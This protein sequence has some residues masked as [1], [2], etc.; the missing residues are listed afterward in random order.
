MPFANAFVENQRLYV[1]F[2]SIN[3]TIPVH[4]IKE[5]LEHFW[6]DKRIKEVHLTLKH[7]RYSGI[8]ETFI[9]RK[10]ISTGNDFQLIEKKDG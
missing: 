8:S 1:R 3:M 7:A 5:I 4:G 2:L 6:N 9:L 10:A